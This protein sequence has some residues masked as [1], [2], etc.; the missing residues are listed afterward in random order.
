M[1]ERRFADAAGRRWAVRV[2]SRNEW[3]FEPVDGNP[4]PP[5]LGAP[6]GYEQDPFELSVEELQRLVDAARTRR[7]PRAPSPFQG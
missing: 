1:A 2:R 4:E 3:E 6:A 7:P 5:R